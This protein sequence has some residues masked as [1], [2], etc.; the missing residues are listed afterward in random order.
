MG[1]ASAGVIKLRRRLPSLFWSAPD[2]KTRRSE[3]ARLDPQPRR[4]PRL[5]CSFVPPSPALRFA[6]RLLRVPFVHVLGPSRPRP[7][8]LPAG[9]TAAYGT[10]DARALCDGRLRI[11]GD[12]AG[13]GPAAL[14]GRRARTGALR[15]PAPDRSHP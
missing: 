10:D 9:G 3:A 15:S 12:A 7:A 2:R 8:G 5:L 14:R 13:G 4:L 6:A 11:P 1:W